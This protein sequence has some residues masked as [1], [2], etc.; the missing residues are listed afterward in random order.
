MSENADEEK[1]RIEADYESE[2]TRRFDTESTIDRVGKRV[3]QPATCPFC[4][5][6]HW[7]IESSGDEG[8]LRPAPVFLLKAPNPFF[9]ATP[10]IPVVVYTCSNCGFVRMHNIKIVL[11]SDDGGE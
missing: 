1:A 5:N 6:T 7:F 3:K 4:E 10:S 2:L 8:S 11:E 9:G